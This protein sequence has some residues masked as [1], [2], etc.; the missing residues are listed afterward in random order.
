VELSEEQWDRLFAVNVKS[1]FLTC[2]YVLP[3]M[4][5]QGKGAIVNV[6]SISSMR[7]VGY[8]SVSY[9]A[10]KGAVNQLTRSIAVQYAARGIRANCVL[11]GAMNTPMIR[12]PLKDV[13]GPGGVEE[14]IRRRDA[15]VPMGK[16]GDAWDVAY[17][18]LFL[19]SDEARY[20]TG[21]ELV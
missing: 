11:P 2:K 5:R 7:W 13:Y 1:M 10:S 17:A 4:E 20:V 15:M 16:M 18:V 6:S 9:S 3:V 12:E 8:P 21:A 14:M 19:A